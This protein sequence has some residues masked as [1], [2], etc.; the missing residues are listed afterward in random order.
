MCNGQS[1]YPEGR[2]VSPFCLKFIHVGLGLLYLSDIIH[3]LLYV[4]QAIIYSSW[5]ILN[6]A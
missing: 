3:P 1:S 4:M 2:A 5:E 6:N